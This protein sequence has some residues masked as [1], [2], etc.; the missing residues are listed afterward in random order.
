[1]LNEVPA[2]SVGPLDYQSPRMPPDALLKF[3]EYPDGGKLERGPATSSELLREAMG[4]PFAV[5]LLGGLAAV[6]LWQSLRLWR[7]PGLPVLAMAMTSGAAVSLITLVWTLLDA[8]QNC[9]VV[10]ELEVR[11]PSLTW[12]KQSFWG[13]R[14]SV[15]RTADVEQV[16][17]GSL[18]PML[19]VG[20]RSRISLGAFSKFPKAEL[21][22]AAA[23][24]T[25][26]VARA[27]AASPGG[28]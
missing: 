10:T 12:T 27:R 22:S 9:G 6:A 4:P 26:A 16:Y 19:R 24:L 18:E 21:N 3:I 2:R 25:L 1:V 11:G 20:H 8:F 7:R 13:S 14:R 28:R 5:L 15:W 17:V 23:L